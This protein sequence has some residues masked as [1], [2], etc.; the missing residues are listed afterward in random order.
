MSDPAERFL[1]GE[2]SLRDD[3]S[4]PLESEPVE[5]LSERVRDAFVREAEARAAHVEAAKVA[6]RTNKAFL[7]CVGAREYATSRLF[8][9]ILAAAKDKDGK[10]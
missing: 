8:D 6:N 7:E 9:A 10:S 5:V 2:R 3:D 1:V 4:G